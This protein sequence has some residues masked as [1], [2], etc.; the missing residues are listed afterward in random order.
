MRLHTLV[1]LSVAL[2]AGFGAADALLNDLASPYGN[3][4][5]HLADAGLLWVVVPAK[6]AGLWIHSAWAWAGLGLLVGW[7][8][9]R[10]V[11]GAIGSVL[12]LL[13]AT[14]AYYVLYPVLEQ[15]PLS[16]YWA[17][18]SGSDVGWWWPASVIFGPLLGAVGACARSPGLIG[19]L[20][21]LALP[22]G[23]TV[24][25]LTVGPL[26]TPIE[27]VAQVC[28]VL[29]AALVAGVV[30]TR[31]LVGRTRPREDSSETPSVESTDMD[32][33]HNGSKP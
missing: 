5:G 24:D 14:T 13:S 10:L 15:E 30:M 21:G 3:I 25:R 9:K 22:L 18:L 8:A 31:Y 4:G 7:I 6:L 27:R 26:L 20:A 2:G 19:L 11:A 29:A 12:A 33:G 32:Q 28:V 1:A 23:M 17:N 16:D